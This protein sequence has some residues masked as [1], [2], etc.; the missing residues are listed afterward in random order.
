MPTRFAS[1]QHPVLAL[2]A[3]RI[4]T[5]GKPIPAAV[6]PFGPQ[7]LHA[8]LDR[9]MQDVFATRYHENDMVVVPVVPGANLPG[10]PEELS[11]AENIRLLSTL[12]R[13][14]VFRHLLTVPGNYRVVSRR[15]PI[16]ESA[17]RENVIPTAAG[18]PPWLRKRVVLVFQTR[19]IKHPGE[20]PYVVL[21]C[22]N[23]LR[24][25]IDA[26]CGRLHEIGVPLVGSYVS[27]WTDNPDPKVAR[28]LRFAGKVVS[29]NGTVLRLSDHGN[30]AEELL[31]NSAFLEPTRANF[32]A[33]VQALMQGSAERVLKQVQEAEGELRAGKASLEAMQAALR[34]FGRAGLQIAD[35]V[36][37]QFENLL[38]QAADPA[39]PPAEVFLKP[40]FSFDP[41]GSRNNTWTQG[42]LDRTGP[43]D[44]ATF[45]RKRPRIAVVCE[46]RR[47]GDVAVTVAHFLDGLPHIKSHKG[48]V[49]HGT[50][51]V[52][53]F[54]LQKP[55]VEFFEAAEDSAA[56]YTDAARTALAAAAARDNPWDLGLVQV[57]RAWR[58][59][60]ASN[61][62]YWSTKAAFLRRD[63]PVQ[64][65]SAEMMGMPDFE[66]A[67]ALANVSLATYAKLGGTPFLLMA[68]PSTD[69]ELVFGLGSHTR[70][71]GRRGAGERVVGITTVF[72]SQGNYL[73]DARTAAVPFDR[74]PAE[75]RDTLV[76]AVK[77]VRKE[78]AWRASDTVRLIFHAFTPLR[79]ETA[80]AVIA[81]V[82]GL[83][84]SG[85][86]FAFL[87]V[88][89]DHPYTLFD[90]SSPTGK[91]AYAPERGQAMELSEQEWLL[92]LTGRDQ[93]RAAFQGI[94][95]PVLLR[96]HEKSTFRDMRTLTR[97]ICDFACHSWRTY[98][99]ARLPITLL[100]ADEIAKQLAGLER[101]P[102]WDPDIPVVGAVMRRPWFL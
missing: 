101:T 97:Q 40:T 58:E 6:V 38:D 9:P 69:H 83:N 19:I 13:E 22:G 62:P 64:A 47:R 45:E 76:E 27:T 96:L 77:R 66:Y 43:Y 35:G 48:L 70:K 41:G 14:A 55:H 86:K 71:E 5:P 24:T 34:Y 29:N 36:P 53:R 68:R 81:A 60:P 3:I 16:V 32:N 80:D 17:K 89:E 31:L 87:H 1:G 61:S 30:E 98:D 20:E 28:R 65:L 63:V 72:S 21:T 95:D 74:Y 42:Q 99:R 82:A 56:A 23:R 26:D 84:L 75:L 67:C 8:F 25:V 54:R 88:A 7:E 2:N 94:P 85:V 44:Q 79:H 78:E 57:Q 4:R 73:L 59:R 37:L 91:G 33:V 12:V 46:A 102:G 52:G 18:L 51:L 10:K 93:V 11:P 100:Y 92:A 50:G 90:H 39:F 49:P 15:P